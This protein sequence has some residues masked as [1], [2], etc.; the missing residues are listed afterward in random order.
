MY[1]RNTFNRQGSS[2]W[3]SKR[4]WEHSTT[5]WWKPGAGKYWRR[6]W[7]KA[8]RAMW[9]TGGRERSVAHYG[10]TCNWKAW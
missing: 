7:H 10:S 9:R 6:R 1:H 3:R 2:E 4:M 8:M 5:A